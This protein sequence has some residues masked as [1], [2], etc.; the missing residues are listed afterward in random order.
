[1]LR[2]ATTPQSQ[3]P[4]LSA[5]GAP[6]LTTG[7]E[8]TKRAAMPA[9][10]VAP[11]PTLISIHFETLAIAF[12]NFTTTMPTRFTGVLRPVLG[13]KTKWPLPVRRPF[14]HMP[15]PRLCIFPPMQD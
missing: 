3:P 9:L 13:Q 6:L 2:A 8:A 11:L 4:Q 1:M 10:K 15:L 14:P 12:V 7:S 5:V